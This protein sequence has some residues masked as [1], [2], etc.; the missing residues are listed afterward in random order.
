LLLGQRQDIS[1]ELLTDYQ[2]AGAIH[3]LAVSGLHV[4]VLLWMLSFLF[5]PIERLPYGKFLKA[6]VIVLLLWGF[7]FIA[8]LSASVVRAVTMFTFLAI[9]QSFQRKHVVT[10]SLIASMFFL[11]LIKPMFIFDVG[12]QLS[13]LAVFG[14]VWLQPKLYAVWKPTFTW[15]HFFWQLCT[16]SIAAQ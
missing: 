16:V 9:G 5:Q 3:I 11:L 12:F 13:Y 6:I 15:V 7:A 1:K 2:K 14:I 8:G 10:Y 4:G